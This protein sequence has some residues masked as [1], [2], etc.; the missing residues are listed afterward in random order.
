MK[1]D[2]KAFAVACGITWGICVFCLAL[3]TY[4]GYAS[5]FVELISSVYIG[6]KPGI[7]GAVIGAFWGFVDAGI[8]GL[9]LAWIYNRIAKK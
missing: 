4:F 5:E 8:G 6:Y 2:I 1:L 3:L 7:L 9:V